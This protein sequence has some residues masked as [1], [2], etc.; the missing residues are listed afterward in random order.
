MDA[1]FS[2]IATPIGMIVCTPLAAI[3]GIG[4]LF[5]I[6]GVIAITIIVLFVVTGQ[7]RKIDFDAA[8]RAQAEVKEELIESTPIE[9]I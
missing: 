1:T 9:S 7:T 6:C 5:A 3:F 2:S 8:E 4:N